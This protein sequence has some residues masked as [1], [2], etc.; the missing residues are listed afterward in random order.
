LRDAGADF[1]AE[2]AGP[3]RGGDPQE[4][5]SKPSRARGARRVEKALAALEKKPKAD[6]TPPMPPPPINR[7]SGLWADD[8]SDS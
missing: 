3:R 7:I 5:G 6:P 8:M 1:K 2:G 4:R